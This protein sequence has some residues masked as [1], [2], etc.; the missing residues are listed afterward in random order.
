MKYV[1]A[2]CGVVVF[3]YA[4]LFNNFALNFVVPLVTYGPTIEEL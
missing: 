2:P 3:S 4:H 1:H